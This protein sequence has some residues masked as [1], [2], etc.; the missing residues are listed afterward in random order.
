MH[1][2]EDHQQEDHQQEDHQQEAPED[3]PGTL[4]HHL[5]DHHQHHNPSQ[6]DQVTLA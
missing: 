4:R 1:R 2:Q 3:L 5:P 6:Q